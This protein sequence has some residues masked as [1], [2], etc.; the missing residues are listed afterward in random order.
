MQTSSCELIRNVGGSCLP[1]CTV[2]FA[3]ES[4][5]SVVD[6]A[7]GAIGADE[8]LY[9]LGHNAATVA[10]GAAAGGKVGAMAGAAFGPAG[11]VAGGLVGGLVG[12]AVASGAY[13][14]AMQYAPE[15]AQE[16]ADQAESFAK[17]AMDVIASEYPDQVDS[18][19]TAFNEFFASN[20]VPV[21]I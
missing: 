9:E 11:S 21:H 14:T 7:Q 15:D 1:A 4:Y 16:I 5:D 19:R 12:S 6:Y 10:G 18:A 8:L 17:Q 3:V 20:G 13:E 2:T